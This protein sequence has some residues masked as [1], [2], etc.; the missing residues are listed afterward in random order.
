MRLRGQLEPE[1]AA[2][3]AMLPAGRRAIDIGANHGVY[4]YA[5]ARVCAHV[6]AFEPQIACA[7][8]L[9]AW[10]HPRVR[11]HVVG[12]SDQAGSLALAVPLA[13]GVPATGYATFGNVEGDHM[14]VTAAVQRLDDFAFQ[15]VAFVKIDV[16]GHE[17]K[18]IAGATETLK[19]ER[20]LVLVEIEQRHLG[21]IPIGSVFDQLT[22]L[23][24]TGS[25]LS[26]G[27]WQSL[28]EFSV[29]R[30]QLAF[31]AGD[32]R[33]PYINNFLFRP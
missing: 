1:L 16:E 4:S 21:S 3:L 31:V 17:S 32:T 9:E 28:R 29:E 8:S 19:R 22:S 5:L 7:R 30:D 15:D 25:Y 14:H 33:A 10:N 24:Y 13:G 12:L 20:P 27:A 2:V 23:G 6:E 18:V 26:E 11:V